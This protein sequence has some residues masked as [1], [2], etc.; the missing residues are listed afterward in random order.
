MY[1]SVMELSA[2]ITNP[3]KVNRIALENAASN[4][5]MLLYYFLK[6]KN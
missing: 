1:K 3:T 6:I 5:G 4:A 2:N